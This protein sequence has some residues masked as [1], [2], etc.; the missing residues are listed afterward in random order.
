MNVDIVYI[1]NRLAK[2]G[3]SPTGVDFLGDLLAEKYRVFR[4]S[5]KVNMLLRLI[6]W[7]WSV[8]KYRKTASWFILDVYSTKN[9]YGIVIVSLLLQHFR[10][11]Y[12]CVLHGGN[13]EIRLKRS[14]FLSNV[15]FNNANRLVAP[16]KFLKEVFKT[17]DYTVD[18]IVNPIDKTLYH[19]K[20][21]SHIKPNILWVRAFNKIYN[22]I[23]A[24]IILKDLRSK[25]IDANMT[26]VGGIKDDSFEQCKSYCFDNGLNEYVN[27][28]GQI[29]KSD[30][31]KL[32]EKHDIFLNTTTIDNAPVSVVEALVL[33][34]IVVSSNVGGLR[35][36]I[37]RTNGY[38]VNN[39]G[40]FVSTIQ[41]ILEKNNADMSR[42]AG[43]LIEIYDRQSVLSRWGEILA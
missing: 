2:R 32:S 26:M 13:L 14:P 38:L 39:A 24:L 28:T 4:T 30:W 37:D 12:I 11:N 21:R 43:E 7:M 1:G 41:N 3:K 6:D 8:L 20:L 29:G 10:L 25:G 35:Y 15:L 9:F 19:H 31:I 22:P 5:D 36:L 42:N 34:M 17:Y 16:S 23:L 33:G 40:E 18:V 27:F